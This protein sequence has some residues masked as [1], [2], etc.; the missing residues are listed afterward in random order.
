MRFVSQLEASGGDGIGEHKEGPMA[1]D[2]FVESLDQEVVF[3]IQ[4]RLQPDAP[5]VT[6]SGTVDGVAERHIVGRHRF[7]DSAGG[8]THLKKPA[9]YLLTGPDFGERAVLLGIEINLERFFVRSDIHFGVHLRL[10]M[11]PFG[12]FSTGEVPQTFESHGDAPCVAGL[13]T[14]YL[15]PYLLDA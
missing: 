12:G 13:W 4:H 2:L 8:A 3:S 15:Q 5:Y 11:W 1:A 10:N 9:G 14:S 6:I 7:S